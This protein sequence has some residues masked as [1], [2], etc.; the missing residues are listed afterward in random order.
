M[1]EPKCAFVNAAG[2]T[3]GRPWEME[4]VSFYRRLLALAGYWAC[5]S[6][7]FMI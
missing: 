7:G 3:I 2:L 5:G 6:A 1:F 4:D